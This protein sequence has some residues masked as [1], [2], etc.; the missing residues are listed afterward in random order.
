MPFSLIRPTLAWNTTYRDSNY[1]N[2][3]RY[4]L[5][6][7]FPGYFCWSK[8]NKIVYKGTPKGCYTRF[9][10]LTGIWPSIS[11]TGSKRYL[12]NFVYIKKK[13][14]FYLFYLIQSR[15]KPYWNKKDLCTPLLLPEELIVPTDIVYGYAHKLFCWI[16]KHLNFVLISRLS[17]MVSEWENCYFY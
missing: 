9:V 11:I 3:L 16:V 14:T 1:K 10:Y 5:S 7:F 12:P 13:H 17:R 6:V 2:T 8:L 4:F 15:R